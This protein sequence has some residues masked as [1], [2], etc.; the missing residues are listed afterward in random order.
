MSETAYVHVC[1]V[2]RCHSYQ[3]GDYRECTEEN[4]SSSLCKARSDA[5]WDGHLI[6]CQ[7]KAA[8]CR[9]SICL[10]SCVYIYSSISP[11]VHVSVCVSFF[12]AGRCARYGMPASPP[13]LSLPA[14]FR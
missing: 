4:T 9:G 11:C 13:P 1:V 7:F 3:G 5:S 8:T 12:W 14:P 2:A 6:L 10:L